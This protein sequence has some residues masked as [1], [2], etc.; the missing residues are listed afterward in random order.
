MLSAIRRHM[1]PATVIASL[2]LVFAMT[3]GAY[4]AG[5]YLI[6]STK[7]ISPKVLRSLKGASGARGPAGPA[8]PAG[9]AGAAGSAGN[10]GAAG[11]KGENG[12]PGAKGENGAPGAPGKEGPTGQPWVPD[13]TLPSGAEETGVWGMTKLTANPGAGGVQIP[14]SFT[15]PLPTPLGETQVHLI[16]EGETGTPGAGCGGGTAED[17]TAEAGNLCVYITSEN[18]APKEVFAIA[19][20]ATGELGAGRTGAIL[21]SSGIP[22]LEA[23]SFAHG[24][25]VLHSSE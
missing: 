6:T 5:K 2:A 13:N 22:G 24:E 7:Q 3:G 12:A 23:G 21:T 25:W 8:G 15:I 14:I 20:P 10:T 16:E 4:A 17:P 19:E 18:K 9:A 11:A 1:T